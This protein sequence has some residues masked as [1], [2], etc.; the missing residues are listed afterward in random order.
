MQAISNWVFQW[1]M[2][3]NRDPN[4]EAQ[5]VYFSKKANNLSSHPVSFN[6]TK[7]V[8]CSSQKHLG[9][10][11]DQQLN[12]SDHIQSKMSKCYKMIG[13][14]KRLSVNIPR[15][16]LLRVFKSLIRPYLDYGDIIYD[17]PNNESFKNKI[18]KIQYKS[19]IAITGTIQGTSRERLYQELA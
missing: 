19:C 6:N 2:Q 18:E 16:T 1:K 13:I 10:V 11:L 15:D 17:K 9:L 7:V 5:E 12:F 14:I 3:F 8:T 4:K